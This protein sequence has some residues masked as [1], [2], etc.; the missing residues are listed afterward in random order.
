MEMTGGCQCGHVRY[1]AVVASTDAYYCH[2]R[3]CQRAFGN[4]FA[5]LL[6]VK[7]SEV[8]WLAEVPTYF[9]SSKL[10]RRG[11]CAR[12]GTPLTF[13]YLDNK[14]S[15]DLSVGSLDHPELLKPTCHNGV[16]SRV[17]S[18]VWADDLPKSRT[19]DNQ[20]YVEKWQAAYGV[21]TKP[22]PVTGR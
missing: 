7:Q 15:M 2:C 20:S 11:F 19:E 14:R 1:S 12:C 8:T 10:A 21:D 5:T 16:E 9:Q 18:F 3:M 4:I 13:E 6:L 17:P 22:G